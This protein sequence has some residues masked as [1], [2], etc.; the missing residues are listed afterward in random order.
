T[1][2]RIRTS[3][4][5]FLAS[6]I[7]RRLDMV[8]T[9]M[10]Q[11]YIYHTD[12][13]HRPEYRW[14]SLVSSNASASYPSAAAVATTSG[15]WA[16]SAGSHQNSEMRRER[17]AIRPV[18]H[19]RPRRRNGMTNEVQ[20]ADASG[21]TGH[22][23]RDRAPGRMPA[24]DVRPRFERGLDRRH[25]IA[26]RIGRVRTQR[27]RIAGAEHFARRIVAAEL[28]GCDDGAISET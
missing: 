5:P 20:H 16:T 1:M 17:R 25:V 19:P 18:R 7:A 11:P 13:S 27:R 23:I 6:S 3:A 4:L 14:R 8:D 24:L 12:R 10:K 26:N 9:Y 15:C 28:L 22:E 2:A 21:E